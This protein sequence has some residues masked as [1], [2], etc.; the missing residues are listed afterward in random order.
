MHTHAQ[1]ALTA[2]DPPRLTPAARPRS[3][4]L[5]PLACPRVPL[6]SLV[7]RQETRSLLIR[8]GTARR[9]AQCKAEARGADGVAAIN[10]AQRGSRG[11][12]GAVGKVGARRSGWVGLQSRRP[13]TDRQRAPT[14]WQSSKLARAGAHVQQP[15]ERFAPSYL[16]AFLARC[17]R[18]LLDSMRRQPASHNNAP[19]PH[20]VL[21][22][23]DQP[24]R[25]SQAT[26]V[27]RPANLTSPRKATCHNAPLQCPIAPIAFPPCPAPTPLRL[28]P[29]DRAP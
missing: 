17:R 2:Q 3:E 23:P 18:K 25:V 13:Q 4:V 26:A 7:P 1:L 29:S 12:Q 16:A 19:D 22:P 10:N 5:G 27:R 8:K 11:K 15:L 21:A 28:V 14:P 9:R 20:S 6:T 24:D